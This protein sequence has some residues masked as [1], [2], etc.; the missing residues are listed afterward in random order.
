[1]IIRIKKTVIVDSGVKRRN[2]KMAKV[3]V[4][5][6]FVRNVGIKCPI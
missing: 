3:H 6:V 2:A 4:D 1:M 5:I